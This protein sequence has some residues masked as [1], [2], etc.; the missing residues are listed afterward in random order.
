MQIISKLQNNV[1]KKYF[2]MKIKIFITILAIFMFASCQNNNDKEISTDIVNNPAT[3]GKIKNNKLPEI[4]F[5]QKTFD[6]G[7]IEEGE[8]VSHVFKFK[9]TG[10]ADL[11]IT[12]VEASCGCTVAKYSKKPVAPGEEGMIEVIFDTS[13]RQGMQHKTVTILANTQP[14]V[15]K[16]EFTAEIFRK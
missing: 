2:A 3:A 4:T 13:G 14:N 15:T 9:N 6:F 8:K 1:N 12:K 16:L 5:K 7:A 11:V 10:N